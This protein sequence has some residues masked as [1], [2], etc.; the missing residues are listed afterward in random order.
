M[1]KTGNSGLQ[2]NVAVD[3]GRRDSDFSQMQLP[4]IKGIIGDEAGELMLRQAAARHFA[5]M[6]DVRTLI[7]VALNRESHVPVLADAAIKQLTS[8]LQ[9]PHLRFSGMDE[10]KEVAQLPAQ[11]NDRILLALKVAAGNFWV[12]HAGMDSLGRM[13]SEDG[14]PKESREYAAKKLDAL[15]EDEKAYAQLRLK[16][17]EAAK[18]R[19]PTCQ[20]SAPDKSKGKMP[21]PHYPGKTPADKRPSPPSAVPGGKIPIQARG[22]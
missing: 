19:K 13:L 8:L 7:K 22:R 20:D 4:D 16:K 15:K 11:Q 21:R 6:M 18:S 9:N 12:F 1:S 10:L 2:G 5:A 14:W 17:M 3:A